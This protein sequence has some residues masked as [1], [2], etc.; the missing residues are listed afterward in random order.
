LRRRLDNL[1]MRRSPVN[2]WIQGHTVFR[3]PTAR[4]MVGLPPR[5]PG[6]EARFIR[7]LR[8]MSPDF[9]HE[10][11][12]GLACLLDTRVY[13]ISQLLRDSDAASMAHSL[14]LRVPLVDLEVVKFSRSCFDHYKLNPSGGST[15]QYQDSG[16]KRVLIH[17]LRD[18]LPPG[19]SRRPKRGF[20]LP[21]ETWI[22]GDLASLVEE[23]CNSATVL[24]RGLV[25]PRLAEATWEAVR[26]GVGGARYPK[27][28]SLMIL[29]LWCR[30]V[31]DE[32]AP[33]GSTHAS[34]AI[35]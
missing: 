34:P 5:R 27:L 12:V 22:G 25:D 6:D 8:E 16:S 11:P 31:L 30:A 19:I 3:Y 1:A 10:T 26:T 24:R 33:V 17:A 29:E 15:G 4:R 14:E 23:T 35:A 18:L 28:W 21:C 32:Q 7:L 2:M 13:L 20:A 9:D